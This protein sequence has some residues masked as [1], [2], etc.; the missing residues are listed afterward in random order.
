LRGLF[1]KRMR[2]HKTPSETV[3]GFKLMSTSH[4]NGITADPVPPTAYLR[5]VRQSRPRWCGCAERARGRL[6][7]APDG[8][9]SRNERRERSSG[10]LA[11]CD[12]LASN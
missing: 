3:T 12:R 4:V 6:G 1:G 10:S 7:K 8:S 5:P 11:M 9:T 2:I